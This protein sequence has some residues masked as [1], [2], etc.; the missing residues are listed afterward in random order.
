MTTKEEKKEKLEKL[1]GKIISE[2]ESTDDPEL[3]RKKLDA[4]LLLVQV[5]RFR[6]I[7]NA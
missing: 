7:K 1:E 6:E 3:L 4:L 5:I 2:L